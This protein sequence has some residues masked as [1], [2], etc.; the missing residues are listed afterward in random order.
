MRTLFILFC[1]ALILNLVAHGE[2]TLSA[3]CEIADASKST[4]RK[5]DKWLNASGKTSPV[6]IKAEMSGA[7]SREGV[8]CSNKAILNNAL[9]VANIR[10]GSSG[11]AETSAHYILKQ[12]YDFIPP[13]LGEYQEEAARRLIRHYKQTRQFNR[14]IELWNNPAARETAYSPLRDAFVL[15]TFASGDEAYTLEMLWP[16]AGNEVGGD[17]WWLLIFASALAE[18]QGETALAQEFQAKADGI[19]T[20]PK[21][22]L[23]GDE[24]NGDR[25][26]Q[27][28]QL[29]IKPRS[30]VGNMTS[31]PD[32]KFPGSV[33][34]RQ[35]TGRCDV[36]FDISGDGR[37]ENITPYCTSD[38]FVRSS[39]AGFKKIRFEPG[40]GDEVSRKGVTYSVW[41]RAESSLNLGT[42]EFISGRVTVRPYLD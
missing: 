6:D 37:P 9:H 18:R 14:L 4:I 19:F 11:D 10:W 17:D 30:V 29:A 20:T 2:S 28:F 22:V 31:P 35:V 40:I 8:S 38:D 42:S 39:R 1:V 21:P 7:M 15:A 12:P 5:I 36:M 34:R 27:L 3:D 26:D 25:L 24:L 23:L 13:K 16:L 32:I 33:L 41:F